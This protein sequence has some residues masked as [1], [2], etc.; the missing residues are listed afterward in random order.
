MEMQLDKQH[1]S[2]VLSALHNHHLDKHH[3]LIVYLVM[4]KQYQVKLHVLH[5]L[6]VLSQTALVRQHVIL[7]QLVQLN[8]N[9]ENHHV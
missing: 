9:L 4:L 8:L 5:V 1:V 6:Q 3:V 2:H 7:V